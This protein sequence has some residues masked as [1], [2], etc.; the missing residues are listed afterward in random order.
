MSWFVVPR[1]PIG[2]GGPGPYAAKTGTASAPTGGYLT[3][4]ARSGGSG[5]SADNGLRSTAEA[6][7]VTLV[8]DGK[9]LEIK[10][11]GFAACGPSIRQGVF[12]GPKSQDAPEPDRPY[13]PR[14]G[15]HIIRQW[16]IR[17]TH[18]LRRSAGVRA[19]S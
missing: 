12:A 16:R 1:K 11:L 7:K 14:C 2:S 13:Y 8:R 9:R 17:A 6:P 3:G 19:D 18:D 10:H 4:G 5:A 15:L